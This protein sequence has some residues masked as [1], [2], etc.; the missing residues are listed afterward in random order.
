VALLNAVM[1]LRVSWKSENFNET[2]IV[3][4]DITIYITHNLYPWH[5]NVHCCI[6]CVHKPDIGNV[7]IHI[8]D[9]IKASRAAPSAY[10]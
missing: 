5:I 7:D 10:S 2:L 1:N 9:E 3:I 4:F 6:L 8:C